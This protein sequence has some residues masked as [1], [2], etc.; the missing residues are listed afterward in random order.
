MLS[1]VLCWR[2]VLFCGVVR[3]GCCVCCLSVWVR[4]AAFVVVW[5]VVWLKMLLSL[6]DVLRLCVGVAFVCDLWVCVCLLCGWLGVG[7]V[8]RA[9]V[10]GVCCV[11]C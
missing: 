8:L 5:C 10:C 1:A 6:C 9:G 4:V 7:R 11:L 3:L 2:G